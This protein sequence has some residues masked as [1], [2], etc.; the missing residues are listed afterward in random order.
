MGIWLCGCSALKCTYITLL[1]CHWFQAECKQAWGCFVFVQRVGIPWS[2][3]F[4]SVQVVIPFWSYCDCSLDCTYSH[5]TY[6]CMYKMHQIFKYLTSTFTM[7]LYLMSVLWIMMSAAFQ[8]QVL[9]TNIFGV[10][11]TFS[12]VCIKS[13]HT[14][15]SKRE[16]ES[17]LVHGSTNVY[18]ACLLPFF[19]KNNFVAV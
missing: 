18:Y 15:K 2:L 1:P 5:T 13:Y 4:A 6:T 10:N 8:C 7:M 9:N 12:F 14:R 16:R 3:G 19:F 17:V 11:K